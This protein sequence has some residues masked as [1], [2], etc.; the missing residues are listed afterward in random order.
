M[1]VLA[2][3]AGAD[4]GRTLARRLDPVVAADAVARDVY[5]VEI[6]GDPRRGRVAVVTGVATRDMRRILA[7]GDDAVMARAASAEHLQVVYGIG[8]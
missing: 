4:V 6:R 2:D 1:A 3:V 8:G 7:G 5:V